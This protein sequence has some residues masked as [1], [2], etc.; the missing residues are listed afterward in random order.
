[1][2]SPKSL[3]FVCLLLVTIK[4]LSPKLN[5]H[6]QQNAQTFNMWKMP[7]SIIIISPQRANENVNKKKKKIILI[8]REKE[9]IIV[10]IINI[11][12]F[13]K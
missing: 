2:E 5:S 4:Q 8:M 1:M 3:A 7:W 9:I 6:E 10:I 11:I 12:M 13:A